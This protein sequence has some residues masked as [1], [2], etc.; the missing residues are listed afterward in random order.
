[1]GQVAET[2]DNLE[3]SADTSYNMPMSQ[4]DLNEIAEQSASRWFRTKV[5]EESVKQAREWYHE[6]HLVIRQMARAFPQTHVA[7]FEVR[8]PQHNLTSLFGLNPKSGLSSFLSCYPDDPVYLKPL[9][10]DAEGRVKRPTQGMGT[11]LTKI[12]ASSA[13]PLL[14]VP[15][16][17]S[18][19]IHCSFQYS[20]TLGYCDWW[21]D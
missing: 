13:L 21:L 20:L 8:H 9:D 14:P 6:H 4:A 16:M 19:C 18:C 11:A 5:E 7:K 2:Q 15:S 10:F 1:M 12:L 3:R 17:I